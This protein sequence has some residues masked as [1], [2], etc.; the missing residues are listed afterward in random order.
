LRRTFPTNENFKSEG[1]IGALRRVL[2]AYSIR[3]R[4]VGYCQSMNFLCA[5]ILLHMTEEKAFWTLAGLVEDILPPG[6]ALFY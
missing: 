4:E 6:F 3:N 5:I 1:G 2:V